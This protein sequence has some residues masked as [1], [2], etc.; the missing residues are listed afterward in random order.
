MKVL[1]KPQL[2][3]RGGSPTEVDFR[4]AAERKRWFAQYGDFIDH[5]ARLASRIHADVFTVGVELARMSHYDAE[6]REL[7]AG[8]RKIYGGP[9][10]YAANFGP[11]FQGVGFW[12]ALD[13]IGLDEYYPLPPDLSTDELV[14]RVERV[15]AEYRRPVLFTEVGFTSTVDPE[16]RPWDGNGRAI[17]LE[18]QERCY[19]AIFRAFYGKAWFAGMYWWKVGTNG[20]GGPGDATFTPWGKPAMEVVRN[21]YLHGGRAKGEEGRG[22]F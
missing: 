20:S 14:R 19:E 12:D 8:V 17:S 16:L 2:W 4:D 10:V 3:V 7:I 9:L 1:L 5:Y 21:W 15:E 6:W 22:D 18:D 11:D 13:Y